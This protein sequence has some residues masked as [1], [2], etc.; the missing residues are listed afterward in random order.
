M[1]HIIPLF[2]GLAVPGTGSTIEEQEAV[3]DAVMQILIPNRGSLATLG[4]IVRRCDFERII[5]NEITEE[6][7][8]D[9]STSVSS[10]LLSVMIPI[11]PLIVKNAY[12]NYNEEN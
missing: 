5:G 4:G 7:F 10:Y 6:A 9:I 8:E 12:D 1:T 2:P 3:T 11:L